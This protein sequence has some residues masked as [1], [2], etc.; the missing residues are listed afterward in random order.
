M[1]KWLNRLEIP[2]S[3]ETHP[4]KTGETPE[5]HG[6][7][8]F[9]VSLA[10]LP[11]HFQKSA[12]GHGEVA[13]AEKP[14]RADAKPP[15]RK[16]PPPPAAPAPAAAPGGDDELWAQLEAIAN[17]CCDCWNDSPDSRAAL[18]TSL[19]AMTPEWQRLWIEHL[20]AS[21]GKPK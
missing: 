18:L 14:A 12:G 16:A 9:L 10:P 5:Q 4:R 6:Q 7:E 11:G 20:E 15:K 1:G 2:K 8:V 21:H 3:P 13:K 19:R 17:K